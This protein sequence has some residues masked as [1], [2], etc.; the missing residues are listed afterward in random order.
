MGRDFV[1]GI[2]AGKHT[3]L[4]VWRRSAKAI[5]ALE[6]LTFWDAYDYVR[7]NYPPDAAEIVIE[8][9]NSKRPMYAAS[10]KLAAGR[11]RV[12]Q[13]MAARIGSVRR[14]AELLAERFE[15]HF[16]TVKRVPPVNAKKWTH[17]EFVRVTKW[18]GRS[19]E[20]QR[21]A[22]RLIVGS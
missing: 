10:D 17:E 18:P 14:E 1:L 13:L 9:P 3:G 6:T 22:A 2:D 8:V 20:H 16:Y 7:E 21:D 11:A 5:V 12:G 4:A 15:Y 19:N